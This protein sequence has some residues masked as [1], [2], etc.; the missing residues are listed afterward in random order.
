MTKLGSGL[1]KGEA[2]G[3]NELAAALVNEPEQVHVV[4]ALIDCKSVK[5]DTD[6]GDVE[7]TARIR[8]IEAVPAQDRG[9]AK[10]MMRRQFET[11]TGKTVLPYQ[12]EQ[13]LLA[14]FGNI[15]P[16]TGEVLGENDGGGEK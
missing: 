15:D 9:L 14:A 13:D 5:T 10:A 6:T 11:R 8:R 7:A 1:P 12:L 16:Q 2:N 3:L 4:I